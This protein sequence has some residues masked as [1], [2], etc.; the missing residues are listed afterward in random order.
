MCAFEL[1]L[2]IESFLS[3][4]ISNVAANPYLYVDDVYFC[5][6][7]LFPQQWSPEEAL[8]IYSFIYFG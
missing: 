8:L 5:I 7:V 3:L 4:D 6:I 1:F 2:F